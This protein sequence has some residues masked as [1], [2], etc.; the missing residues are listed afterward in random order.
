MH[1]TMLASVL[2]CVWLAQKPPHWTGSLCNIFL[3]GRQE[4]LPVGCPPWALTKRWPST[5]PVSVT[6]VSP[7]GDMEWRL[8]CKPLVL[9]SFN[10]RHQRIPSRSH[11]THFT[12][13]GEIISKSSVMDRSCRSGFHWKSF[14]GLEN[15]LHNF[16]AH[17]IISNCL[18]FLQWNH[19]GFK[20]YI[21]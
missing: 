1:T 3:Y 5:W 2:L 9:Q 7:W 13:V 20:G 17:T 19:W 6:L 21:N 14:K 4:L 12:S 8:S 10:V 11:S 18:I 15:M 16:T